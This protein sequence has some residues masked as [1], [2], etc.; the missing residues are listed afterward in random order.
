MPIRLGALALLV[1][2][3][4]IASRAADEPGL[5]R[6]RVVDRSGLPAAGASVFAFW[7]ANGL[8]WDQFRAIGDQEA[9]RRW[10]NEGKMEPWGSVRVSTDA[11]G[12]FSIPA[13]ERMKSLMIYDRDRREGAVVVF[14]PRHPEAPIEARL[15]PLVR[16]FGTTRLAGA[17]GPLKW[18]CAYLSL[19]YDEAD[20][21]NRRRIAICGS[22]KTRFEF[23]IPPGTY[24]FSASSD[25]PASATLDAR[26]VV[27]EADQKEID[28]GSLVLRPQV[29]GVQNLIDRAKARGTW[30]DYKQ[31]FGKQPPP[32]HLTDAKGVAKDA[33]LSDF[34]GR[35]AVL[36]FWGPNCPPCLGKELPELMAFYEAYKAQRDRF[37]ILAFCCDFGETLRSIAE[38]ERHLEL[39]KKSVWGGKDLPFP[40]LLDN[41]FQ[42]YERFGLEGSGVSTTLLIDPDGKLVQGD[43][44]SLGKRLDQPERAPR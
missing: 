15:S 7:G 5:I 41:T 2:V 38:L 21:L 25:S 3:S 43:L 8:S 36:Y 4:P 6:G 18:S 40:V 24:E 31:N 44:K 34:K 32:W 9:E 12:R 1:V 37:E 20:P 35:W 19:P 11:E 22:F 28:L 39:V 33:R 10:Q 27:V 17:E 23:S 16:V 29:G 30:G 13:P 14:D 26:K 42:T